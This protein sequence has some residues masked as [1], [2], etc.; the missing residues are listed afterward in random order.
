[1]EKGHLLRRNIHFSQTTTTKNLIFLKQ[2]ATFVIVN[3]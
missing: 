3:R 1:M 2:N